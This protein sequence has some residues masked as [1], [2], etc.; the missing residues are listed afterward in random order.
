MSLTIADIVTRKVLTISPEATIAAAAALMARHQISCIVAVSGGRPVSLVTEADLVRAGSLQLDVDRIMV[1]EFIT[2]PPVTVSVDQSIYEAFDFLIEH[3]IR[4]LVTI[5]PD[6]LLDGLVTFTDMIQAVSLDDF[7]KAKLVEEEMSDQVVTIGIDAPVLD[8]MTQMNRKGI[9]CVIIERDRQPVGIFTERDAA[10]MI[11]SHCQLATVTVA[12]VMTSPLVTLPVGSS[13]LEASETMRNA[14]ISRVIITHQDGSTAG[15]LTQF[16]VIR[17]LEAR[18]ISHF[19]KLHARTEQQLIKSQHCWR[20]KP[21]LSALFQSLRRYC[22][23][24]NINAIR[25]GGDGYQ[26]TSVRKYEPC[27]V[28]GMMSGDSRAGGRHRYTRT[29]WMPLP[30]VCKAF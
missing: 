25:K 10:K 12:S 20:K 11:A 16:D 29:I 26:P 18:R 28:T 14:A 8:A 21:S 22:I 2:H 15:I 3:H 5:T 1:R 23:A 4:H 9:S 30:S 7:M 19:K 27:L 17:G 13:L 24:V 6:G